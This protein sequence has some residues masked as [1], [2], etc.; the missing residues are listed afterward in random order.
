[1]GFYCTRAYFKKRSISIIKATVNYSWSSGSCRPGADAALKMIGSN[2][3]R[4]VGGLVNPKENF[5]GPHPFL[6]QGT[7]SRGIFYSLRH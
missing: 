4:A 1:M 2:G 5:L 7:P 3:I 6:C